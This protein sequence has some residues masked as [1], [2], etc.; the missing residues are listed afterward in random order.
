M[1]HLVVESC[2]KM[3]IS[4]E[5]IERFLQNKTTEAENFL[6]DDWYNSF[7]Y[8][9]DGIS[10]LSE[11]AQ[12]NLENQLYQRLR[13]RLNPFIE[14]EML[15]AEETDAS[16]QNRKTWFW[17]WTAAASVLVLFGL[18]NYNSHDKETKS[19]EVSA[20]KVLSKWAKYANESAKI[21]KVT[22]PD[23]SKVSLFPD[24]EMS[25]NQADRECRQVQL[26]GEA[27]FEVQRDER[28]PF[29]IY[30]GSMTTRVLGTSFNVR[31]YRGSEK[32][33]VSV[34]SGSVMVTNETDKELKLSPRQQAILQ[35]KTD[36]LQVVQLP[37]N[38][39][40]YWENATLIF[41]DTPL[42][43]VVVQ[44]EKK[45]NISFEIS[46]SLKTCRLSGTFQHERLSTVLEIINKTTESDY[47]INGLTIRLFGEGCQ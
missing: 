42:A 18:W 28:R 31:A 35:I 24:T 7:N 40:N 36:E 13:Q 47:E 5:I 6:V 12:I 34:V 17:A 27:F 23:G 8:Q 15:S 19:T 14:V 41:D 29:L 16:V 43:D 39:Q 2:K 46:E 44:L 9:P 26:S 10:N 25:Y 22:L 20:P 1:F 38:Q 33:E 3:K 30:S 32:F 37:A 21:L 45:Y 4:Q 11:L